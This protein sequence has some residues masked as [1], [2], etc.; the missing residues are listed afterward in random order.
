MVAN[1]QGELILGDRGY[2]INSYDLDDGNLTVRASSLLG[3]EPTHGAQ[4]VDRA[5]AS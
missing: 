2:D 1:G 4:G 3:F 5:R